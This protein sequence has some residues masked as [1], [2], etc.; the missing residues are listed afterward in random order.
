MFIA[1]ECYEKQPNC[2]L[3]EKFRH[4]LC[5]QSEKNILKMSFSSMPYHLCNVNMLH[6]FHDGS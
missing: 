4:G 1:T 6:F 5:R 3:L 2:K